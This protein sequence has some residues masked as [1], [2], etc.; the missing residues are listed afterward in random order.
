MTIFGYARAS[1][2]GRTLHG[3][4][5]ALRAAGA[6]RIFKEKFSGSRADRPELTKLL[7]KIA[8]GDQL[9]VTR[10]DRLARSTRDLLDVIAAIAERGATFKSLGDQWADTTTPRGRLMLPVLGGLAA[11][12]RELI[13]ARTSEGRARAK[14]QGRHIGRPAKLTPRQQAQDLADLATGMVTQADL[15]RRHNVSESTISRTVAKAEASFQIRPREPDPETLQAAKAFLDRLEGRYV[16]ALLYGSRARGDHTSDSDA[17]IAVVLKGRRGDRS[18]AVLDLSDAA[19][20]A[21]LE[22]GVYIQPF[23]LWESELRRPGQSKNPALIEN[24]KREGIRL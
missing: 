2:D 12:E 24:I 20:D 5:D 18:K 21:L 17:D 8:K 4:L 13:V 15:A 3:Q 10:L 6:K 11:F 16:K 7:T 19:H 1:I 9:I 23:P 22:T 14:T